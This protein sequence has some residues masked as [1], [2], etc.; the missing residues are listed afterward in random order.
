MTE[1]QEEETNEGYSPGFLSENGII[2]EQIADNQYVTNRKNPSQSSQ[3][4]ICSNL[5]TGGKTY[6]PLQRCP[7]FLAE[8]AII[9]GNMEDLWNETKQFIKEHLYLEDESLYDILTAWIFATWTPEV[10]TVVPYL[11]FYGPVASGKTR[12]LEVLHRL[13]YRGILSA[14][15]SSAALFRACDQWHPTLIL[16]ETEIYNKIERNEVIGLLNSGYRRGQYAIRVKSSEKGEFLQTFDVFGFKALAGTQG[17]AKALESRSVVVKMMKNRRKVRLLIDEEKATEIRGKLL[18]MRINTLGSCDLL[19]VSAVFLERVGELKL[20]NGRLEELFQCLV[21]V[22][23]HGRENILSYA[24]TMLKDRQFEEMTSIEADIVKIMLET[25][26]SKENSVILTKDIT[27]ELNKDRSEKDKF[28]TKSVGWIIRRLGFKP[29]RSGG[30]HGWHYDTDRLKNLAQIY[31]A[32]PE[33]LEHPEK[34][35][36]K[37]QNGILEELPTSKEQELHLHRSEASEVSLEDL[38]PKTL[39]LE[40][41]KNGDWQDRCIACGFQGSMDWQTTTHDG[42]WGLLCG[43]CGIKLGKKLQEVKA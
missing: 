28:K 8:E 21:A 27:D 37:A 30:A 34:K 14:N 5:E 42:S 29:R 31:L 38:A 26:L 39:K 23:N 40:R 7:W 18:S 1:E 17:L 36:Q 41:L 13:S 43:E 11:F 2:F 32:N 35:V 3:P 33:E 10:W 6:F 19:A 12:A 20:E 16:D 24:Q 22:A 15:I 9:Y 25:T 4:E